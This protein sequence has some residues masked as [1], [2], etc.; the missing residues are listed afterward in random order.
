M[1]ITRE[2]TIDEKLINEKIELSKVNMNP[3]ISTL[4]Y[5]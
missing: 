2:Q 1:F 5:K 3:E 4:L